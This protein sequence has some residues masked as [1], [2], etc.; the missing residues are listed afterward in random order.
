MALP[1]LH[2]SIALI[3]SAF[4]LP[5]IRSWTLRAVV[6]CYPVIMLASLVYLGEHWV[7]DGFIGWLIVGGSFRVWNRVERRRRQGA[8]ARA[9]AALERMGAA[10][11]GR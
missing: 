2:A 4:F 11:D 5:W 10:G 6:L 8:A 7:V 9:G 1:S 3:V